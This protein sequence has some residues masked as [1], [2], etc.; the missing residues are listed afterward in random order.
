MAYT[1]N[2][3]DMK[4]LSD[5][6][7]ENKMKVDDLPRGAQL[8]LKSYWEASGVDFSNPDMAEAQLTDLVTQRREQSSSSIFDSPFFKPI[9]WVGSKLYKVYSATVSPILSA[10]GMALHSVL[11]GRPDYIGQDGE[12]DA[13]KDYWDLAHKVSPGQSVWMLG[14][15]DKEL[16]DRGIRPDQISEDLALQAKGEYRDAQTKDDKFGVMT[17]SQEYFGNGAAKYVTGGTDFAVS[18]YLDPLVLTGK[19]AGAVKRAVVTKNV[20]AKTAEPGIIKKG[21]AGAVGVTPKTGAEKFAD[22]S[23]GSTFEA[24]VNKVEQVRKA[25]PDNAALVLRRDMPTIRKSANGDALASLLTQ[26]KDVDDVRDVLRLSIGD[27]AARLPLEIRAAELAPQ[28]EMMT[29]RNVTHAAYYDGLSDAVKASPRGQAIKQA[30]DKQT[31]YVNNLNRQNRFIDDKL[32]AFGSVRDLNYNRVTTPLGMKIKGTNLVQASGK[33][34]GMKGL[35]WPVRVVHSYGSQKPTAH[36]DIHGED[37]FRNLDANLREV[38]GLSREAR[39]MY[40]SQYVKAGVNERQMTLMDIEHKITHNMVDRYNLK[41]PNNK[42]TYELATDLYK[43]IARRRSNGQAAAAK[44]RTYSGGTMPD[45]KDPTQTVRVAEIDGAGGRTVSTP[46]FDTQIANSHVLLDFKLFERS[47]EANGSTWQRMKNTMGDKWDTATAVADVLNTTWKFTQLFRLGY[48]PRA[49]ADDFLGQLARS[50]SVAMLDRAVKGGRVMLEDF[51]RGKWASDSVQAA[52]DSQAMLAQH[53]DGLAAQQAAAKAELRRAQGMGAPNVRQL[54]DDLND[55]TDEIL[56]AKQTHAD[57]GSLVAYGAQMRD[58]KVGRQVFSAPFAGKL[59]E[60]FRDLASGQRNF[61]NLMGSSSD[62]YLK[63]LR[64]MDW[65]DVTPASVGPEKHMDAWIRVINDQIGQSAI[66]RQALKGASEADLV[67]WMRNTVEGQRYRVQINLKN[68]SDYE[69]AQRVKGAVD[70][71]LDPALPGMDQIRRGILEG[72]L[73]KSMLEAIPAR[74]RPVV[75]MQMFGYAEGSNKAAELVD[76]TITGYYNLANQMP[77]TKLLRNPL[78][79]QSYKAHLKEQMSILNSQG[80]THVDEALRKTLEANARRGALQ[81][82]KKYTFTMDHETKMAFHMRHFG[83]FFGAQQESWNR[84]ARIISDKPDVLA[85]VSQV[86]GAPAR[87]GMV[88]DGDG[89]AVDGAGY[90]LDP[91]TGEKKLVKYSDRKT[92]IQ[93]PEYLGGKALNKELGLDEDASFVI[94]MSS[95]EL[96]MNHGDGALPVGAGPFIQMGVNYFAQDDPNIANWAQKMGVLPFG[97]QDSVMDFINPTTGKRL[98][99]SMDDMGETKQR[100]LFY[101]MQVENFKYEQGLRKTKPT[102]GELKDRADRWTIFRTAAAFSLPFSV[103]AQ[104]PYQFFRDEYQRYQKLDQ[105]SADEKFYDKYGDSF[106]MFSQ[107]MSKNNSGLRPT[108]NSV[109]MSKYYSELIDK[110]GPQ[111]AGLVVGA[112]GDGEYSNG[113]FYYQ[114]THESAPGSGETQRSNLSAREAWDKGQVGRG[115]AKY[116][117][118]MEDANAQLFQRG[119]QTFDDP[120]AEDLKGYKRGIQLMLTTRTL[121][122]GTENPYYNEQWEKEFSS[123][124][125]GKYDRTAGDLEGLVNDPELW[126]KAVNPDGTVGIRSDIYTLRGYLELRRQMKAALMTRKIDGGSDDI[127]AQQNYDLKSSWD[128]TVMQLIEADTK[129]AWVHSRYFATD[130]GFNMD[131]HYSAE[132]QAQMEDS[133]AS[134]VGQQ[135]APST[136][137]TDIVD[138]MMQQ[139]GLNG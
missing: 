136:D 55:I 95:L 77:A 89:N 84:W 48:A 32:E 24:M 41:N 1:P 71:A 92:L 76:K 117:N 34:V 23:T 113:A 132:A 131:V 66:G 22:L 9:E 99:D 33:L 139:G 106:F 128:Q 27:H 104:D 124:D 91:V 63:K 38:S 54:E 90:S 100:A 16:K 79:G 45:P 82:V 58:V 62:W 3:R 43:N 109:K 134:V 64:R 37:S 101:A 127:T 83:A 50:G 6:V 68:M 25:N 10:G 81:D 17:R 115:W 69:L 14:L 103:N 18:W 93:I 7:L 47:L 39:E 51:A 116:N 21:L 78:F 123:L 74:N 73:D 13:L 56:T 125:K 129:F 65:E 40:V 86:Y 105:D 110:V 70:H 42:I 130:M 60:L 2:A 19:T 85:R 122:D 96:V 111:Y 28:I 49:L 8:A 57:Y 67:K 72:K 135:A 119:L 75:N 44:Q 120:G 29:A 133:N 11:Y 118:L 114:K 4:T 94:P 46:L 126:S 15:N 26:A 108:D 12:M 31:Q 87:A 97:P 59:G 30:L 107:S 5:S 80:V 88:V 137:G 112:E 121:P 35:G 98:G 53:I 36:I 138:T 102:W 52:R 20:A 61:N